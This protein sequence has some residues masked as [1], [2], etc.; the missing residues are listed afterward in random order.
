MSKK[1]L[2]IWHTDFDVRLS[3]FKFWLH[4]LITV[5]L[6]ASCLKT[7]YFNFLIYNISIKQQWVPTH[8]IILKINVITYKVRRTIPDILMFSIKTSHHNLLFFLKV[9][10][11]I[12]DY[13]TNV[14]IKNI[15]MS[16]WLY[17]NQWQ[18]CDCSLHL[19]YNHLI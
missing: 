19:C 15:I 12:I 2:I 10:L 18:C 1:K 5:S 8:K 7:Q 14:S 3:G 6:W 16:A 11:F 17:Q 4:Y 13:G 9:L